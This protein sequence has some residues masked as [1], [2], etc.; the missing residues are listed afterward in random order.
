M[1]RC[2]VAKFPT[3]DKPFPPDVFEP[4]IGGPMPG[5]VTDS[6][7]PGPGTLVAAEVA[8]DGWS[9]VLTVDLPEPP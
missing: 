8:P 5:W 1:K 9:A 4:H 7:L 3:D 6:E 2:T